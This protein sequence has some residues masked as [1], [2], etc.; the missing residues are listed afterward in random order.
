[1]E[2]V[3]LCLSQLKDKGAQKAEVNVSKEIKEEMNINS[4]E[5]SLLRSL[6]EYNIEMT[7]F[8]DQKKDVIKLNKVDELSIEQAAMEVTQNAKN[9]EPDPANDIPNGELKKEFKDSETQLD[10]EMM[11]R[12]LKEFIKGVNEQYDRLVIEEAILEHNKIKSYYQN[13]GG[14]ELYS[15]D[16]Q[17]N[18]TVM[19]FAK[20][21]K[22]TSSFNYTVQTTKDLD[23]AILQ[24]GALSN[25]LEQS[26]DHLEPKAIEQKKFTGDVI[27]TPDC[28]SAMTYFL[29]SHLSNHYMISGISKFKGKIGEKLLDEKLTIKT[30][31]DSRKLAFKDYFGKDGFVNRNDYLFQDGVLKNYLLNYYGALKTGFERGPSTSV[32]SGIVIEPGDKSFDEMVKSMDQGIILA[33]F[34]GGQPAPNGDFSGI[35]KNSYYVKDGKIQYPIKETMISGNLFDMLE[36]IKAISKERLNNGQTLMPY[37]QLRNAVISSK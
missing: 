2:L 14:V 15:E 33:R 8:I 32:Y 6:E 7:A 18:F 29:L 21:N 31:P 4:G 16:S 5:V 37:I 1:M 36:D 3:K 23:R 20:E 24:L 13:T 30:E 22:K 35:A 34:S 11:H 28:M 17:Y 10:V 12:R 19:F 26:I 9:S 27:I 25:L